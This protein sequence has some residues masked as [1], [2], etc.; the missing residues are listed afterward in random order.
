VHCSPITIP[1][2]PD[3][4]AMAR[5][6]IELENRNYAEMT[7]ETGDDRHS[8]PTTKVASLEQVE[9]EVNG[10]ARLGQQRS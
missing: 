8:G 7:Q 4:Q 6:S 1:D 9:T 5:N 3:T 2:V 10:H